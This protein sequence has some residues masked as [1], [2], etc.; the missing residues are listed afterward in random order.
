M[1]APPKQKASD[2]CPWSPQLGMFPHYTKTKTSKKL[3]TCWALED[4]GSSLRGRGEQKQKK[5]RAG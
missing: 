2:R 4:L 3:N 5:K 1:Q